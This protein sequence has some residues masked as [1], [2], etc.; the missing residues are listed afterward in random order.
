MVP[1]IPWLQMGKKDDLVEKAQRKMA[2]LLRYGSILS[3]SHGGGPSIPRS[4]Q[5][6]E[7]L[8]EK[9]LLG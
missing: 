3:K 6:Q 4:C 5:E 9:E 7:R 2:A 1:S 8:D